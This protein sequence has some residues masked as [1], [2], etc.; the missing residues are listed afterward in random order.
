M[1]YKFFDKK[2]AGT[3]IENEI[4]QNQQLGEELQELIIRKFKKRRV[5]SSFKDT[6]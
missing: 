2:W 3:D 6:I 5:Y 4:T 1:V